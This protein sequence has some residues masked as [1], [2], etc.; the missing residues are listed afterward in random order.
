MP[1]T[2]AYTRLHTL[3][4]SYTPSDTETRAIVGFRKWFLP[5]SL[6]SWQNI[7]YMSKMW[8]KR[9][10]VDDC[11]SLSGHEKKR[12]KKMKRENDGGRKRDRHRH[13]QRNE[14]KRN[15]MEMVGKRVEKYD[16]RAQMSRVNCAGSMG[17]LLDVTCGC[18]RATGAESRGSGGGGGG[19]GLLLFS[20][21]EFDER[22]LQFHEMSEGG[23]TEDFNARLKVFHVLGVGQIDVLAAG[24]KL[25]GVAGAR[26][27]RWFLDVALQEGRGVLVNVQREAIVRTFA[28]VAVNARSYAVVF[29]VLPDAFQL[30]LSAVLQV[31]ECLQAN[32]TALIGTQSYTSSWFI[33]FFFCFSVSFSLFPLVK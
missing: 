23:V 11:F 25:D 28:V 24:R 14:T 12:M 9:G 19:R 13:R 16:G 29:D 4:H 21:G 10:R 5:I 18:A 22:E 2:H 27:F 32:L 30:V 31:E 33:H 15:E 8:R 3:T 17:S 7:W 6:S 26:Y 20:I 1:L